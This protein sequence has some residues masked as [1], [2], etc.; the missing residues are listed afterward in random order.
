MATTV[1]PSAIASMRALFNL[2]DGLCLALRRLLNAI[3]Q[4]AG[5]DEHRR[6]RQQVCECLRGRPLGGMPHAASSLDLGTTHRC[7]KNRARQSEFSLG[8]PRNVYSPDQSP[9]WANIPTTSN[10]NAAAI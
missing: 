2:P 9:H 1:L 10:S 7:A 3:K 8:L 4:D 6:H 5:D